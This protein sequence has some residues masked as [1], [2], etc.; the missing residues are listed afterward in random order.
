MTLRWITAALHLIALVIGAAA[1]G[2]RGSALSRL[3]RDN[4]LRAVFA[5]DTLWGVAAALWIGTGLWRAFGGLEKGSDYYLASHT[6]WTKM[7]LLG[8]IL[9]LELRPMVTL[10][11]WRQSLKRG[12]Q[13]DFSIAPQLA[14]TSRVQ[15]ILLA[16][17]VIAAT[18]MARGL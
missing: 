16:A 17:M 15:L 3:S 4:E 10:I 12:T 1:I 13:I 6:F 8:A 9:L 11:R 5:A 18:A 14:R 2:V 7:A